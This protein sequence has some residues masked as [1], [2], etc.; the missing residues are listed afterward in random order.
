MFPAAYPLPQGTREALSTWMRVTSCLMKGWAAQTSLTHPQHKQRNISLLRATTATSNP[1]V[2]ALAHC[3]YNL[4][5]MYFSQD[6]NCLHH[7]TENILS[8]TSFYR[9]IS[10]SPMIINMEVS[11]QCCNLSQ[12]KRTWFLWSQHPAICYHQDVVL[13]RRERHCSSF[14][15]H[16]PLTCNLNPKSGNPSLH[17]KGYCR[18][19]ELS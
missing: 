6:D 12:L 17:N 1:A 13:Q 11:K 8:W 9:N 4:E 7:C 19:L 16:C 2:T 18:N 10:N 14:A 3:V 5:H 15:P